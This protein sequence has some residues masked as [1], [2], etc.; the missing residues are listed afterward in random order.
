[1]ITMIFIHLESFFVL[2]II[3]WLL[4]LSIRH[5]K[6]GGMD[7]KSDGEKVIETEPFDV[8]VYFH[9]LQV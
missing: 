9:H 5:I 6:Y 2:W 7:H 1:M 8:M 3:V 4:S